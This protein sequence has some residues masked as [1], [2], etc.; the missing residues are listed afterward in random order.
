MKHQTHIE[1]RIGSWKCCLPFIL[2]L[3]T[4]FI[5]MPVAVAQNDSETQAEPYKINGKEVK[6]Y[7]IDKYE[8]KKHDV[9]STLKQTPN[10]ANG[11]IHIRGNLT[12]KKT[13][14]PKK[15]KY[16]KARA[17]AEAFLEEETM[18]L[19]GITNLAD[20]SEF[21]ISGD[22]WTHIL[23]YR[24]VGN[25]RLEGSDIQIHVQPD[26]KIASVEAILVPVNP[27]L[28]EA[29]NRE[30]LSEAEIRKVV[31]DDLIK[32]GIQSPE[33]QSALKYI[34][35]MKAEKVAIRMAPYVIWK[36]KS[37]WVYTINAF[38][39]EILAKSPPWG[40]E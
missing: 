37:V 22:G 27:E 17:V 4:M 9:T 33:V 1:N 20:I 14:T 2:L 3:L 10:G 36:A 35:D 25:L 16:G 24:Y 8:L 32:S 21:S 34:Q 26:G 19:F 28:L 12:P 30:T 38:T 13:I 39:G 23:Y 11:S 7:L 31:K 15:E 5:F 18:P 6:E 40:F 29:V